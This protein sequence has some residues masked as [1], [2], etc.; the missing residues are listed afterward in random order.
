[1][2]K[3]QKLFVLFVC[4][5]FLSFVG[6][7]KTSEISDN[8]MSGDSEITLIDFDGMTK[9]EIEDWLHTHGVNNIVF[10]MPSDTDSRF[11]YSIPAPGSNIKTDS[12][13]I[14]VFEKTSSSVTVPDFSTASFEEIRSWAME[15]KLNIIY[16][17]VS[18]DAIT[19]KTNLK[20]GS[21]ITEGDTIII[22]V[23]GD[24]KLEYDLNNEDDSER[25]DNE[26][27]VDPETD[28]DETE[29]L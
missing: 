24:E 17:Y 5:F 20:P 18:D 25:N 11:S 15:N 16:Q 10:Q 4:V 27:F 8:N 9:N 29:P 1:M 7:R 22:T 21:N 13:I 2:K 12:K 6:C 3:L 23:Q 28:D 19:D 26:Q 14:I